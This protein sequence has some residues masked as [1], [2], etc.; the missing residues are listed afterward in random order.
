MTI[1]TRGGK[2]EGA[3]RPATR[4][5]AKVYTAA[6]LTPTV[7]AFLRASPE[8]VGETVERL[9]RRSLAASQSKRPAPRDE[10][11]RT[12][13]A[14]DT[15]E[16][17]VSTGFRLTPTVRAYLDSLEGP[18]IGGKLEALIRRSKSFRE[19]SA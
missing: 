15:G 19:F 13:A 9:L 2:R 7:L 3:G 1:K 14:N 16:R 12:I 18:S 6:R 8:S 17:K 5:E 10:G 4:G 11:P